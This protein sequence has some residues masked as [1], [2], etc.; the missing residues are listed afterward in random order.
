VI[1]FVALAAPPL[2][3]QEGNRITHGPI[4]GGVGP[5]HVRV[6]ARTERPGSFQVRYGPA[7]DK[8]NETSLVVETRLE[9]DNTGWIQL[10][11]LKPDTK[12]WYQVGGGLGGSFR[13]LPDTDALRDQA[14]NPKGLF[15]LQ[16]EFACGNN[17]TPGRSLGPDVPAFKT[18]LEKLQNRIH[19]AILNGDWLYEDRREHTVAQWSKQV[20]LGKQ[21]PPRVVQDAPTI[22]GVWEN[23]KVYL[24]RG[25]NLAAWHRKV[26]SFFT[27]DDHEILNDVWGAGEPGVKERRAVFRDIG[28]QA[29]YDYLGWANPTHFTQPIRFG[30]AALAKD[31]LTDPAADF[32]TLNLK[33]MTT[34]H[35]HWD[36]PTE[37][38]DDNALDDE[39]PGNPNSGVY[40][41]REVVD[42]HRLRL[43]PPAAADS[44]VRYSIG[45]RSYY[46]VRAANCELFMLDTRSHREMHD[47][48]NRAKKG[49][50][51][52]GKE[53]KDWLM[54]GMKKSDAD[55]L[56]V[57]SSVNLMVPHVGGGAV[58]AK[59]K[60]DAWT[61][62]LDEREQL[63]RF[64]DSLGKPVFVLTGDLHNSFAIKITDRVWEFASGPHNSQNH[65][66]KD[67][68]GRPENG[69]YDSFGRPCDIRWSSYFRDDVPREQARQPFYCVVQVNNVYDNPLRES[70]TR[71]VAYPRPHVVFQ[72]Y[73]GFTGALRYAET[74]QAR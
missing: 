41:I 62:F 66:A 67:E 43:H 23:Y 11:N 55:F 13:T 56:F 52:L 32:S 48:G 74:V 8:L 54:D 6:W 31:L 46:K 5:T 59:N 58:R 37:G 72:Y 63:I 30:R 73:D 2:G 49:L 40:G 65:L 16:F 28:V 7:P 53:Q 47:T 3:A 42:K 44:E 21:Q 29:W 70:Q 68:G 17:Q 18:M 19:F 34:L 57:V 10:E 27:F 50:S 51:M 61:A 9:H 33:E 69:I 38:V 20:G 25:K 35:V 4:L 26:P 1:V 22:V 60:D 14:L 12:Y 39:A 71:W 64:W 36:K 15:N 24:E 45:R